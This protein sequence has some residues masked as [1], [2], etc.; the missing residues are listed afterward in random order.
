MT[1]RFECRCGKKLEARDED[2][3]EEVRCPRCGA[4]ILLP[5]TLEGR[6]G[7]VVGR[8][9]LAW[10]ALIAGLVP[11][12]FILFT[13][14]HTL[15]WDRFTSGSS[16]ETIYNA[17]GAAILLGQVATVVLAVIALRRINQAD[18]KGNLLQG[19][20]E[21]T[22]ALLLGVLWLGLFLSSLLLSFLGVS[23]PRP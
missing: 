20:R 22:I 18:R 8:E 23:A 7:Y 21:A 2:L 17:V 13:V 5:F 14:I 19:E 11:V 4:R 9:P 6:H 16:A 12:A 3:G 10:P 15:A 1:Y